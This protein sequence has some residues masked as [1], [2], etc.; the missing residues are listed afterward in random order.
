MLLCQVQHRT[1]KKYIDKIFER[2]VEKCLKSELFHH[3]RKLLVI[4]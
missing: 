1:A 2:K 3:L 4:K